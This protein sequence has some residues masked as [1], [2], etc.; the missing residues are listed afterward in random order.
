MVSY[1]EKS[2]MDLISFMLLWFPKPYNPTFYMSVTTCLGVMVPQDYI[3]SFKEI[4][5]GKTY[6][7]IAINMY[8]PL[9][10]V[11]DNPK[12]AHIYKL[13]STNS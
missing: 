12:R 11:N 1:I 4:T 10:N 7:K 9:Q 13:A 3:I 6:I 5:I 8:I 2:E